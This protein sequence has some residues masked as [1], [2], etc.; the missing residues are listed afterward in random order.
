MEIGKKL[1]VGIYVRKLPQNFCPF[2]PLILSCKHQSYGEETMKL[3]I[4]A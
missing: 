3:M 4:A 2:M 1:E